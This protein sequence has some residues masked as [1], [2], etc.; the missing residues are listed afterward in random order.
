MNPNHRSTPA[1]PPDDDDP[2]ADEAPAHVEAAVTGEKPADVRALVSELNGHL[3]ATLVA[4][5]SGTRNSKDPYSWA[6]GHIRPGTAQERRLRLA[7]LAWHQIVEA[8][9]EDIARVWFLG[10]N[11]FLGDDSAITALREDRLDEVRAAAQAFITDT[12]AG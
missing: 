5:L 2:V 11:P 7:H 9:S 10:A 12:W 1:Q 3:G 4:A 6:E 8:E